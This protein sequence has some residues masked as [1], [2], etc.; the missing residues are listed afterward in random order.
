[1]KAFLVNRVGDFGF[2][3]GIAGVVYYTEGGLAR[4]RRRLQAAPQIAG[5]EL[6]LCRAPMA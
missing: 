2:M 6:Q 4:L 5:A 1:M 3:L